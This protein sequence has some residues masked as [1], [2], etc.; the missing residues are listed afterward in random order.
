MREE[1][2]NVQSSLHNM[3]ERGRATRLSPSE[4]W[5]FSRAVG[6]VSSETEFSP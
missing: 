5:C 4:H 2:V 1:A 3:M 6:A